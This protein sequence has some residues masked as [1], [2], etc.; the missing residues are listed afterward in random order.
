MMGF[1]DSVFKAAVTAAVVAAAVYYGGG[2]VGI[3]F[4]SSATAYIASAA[5]TAAAISTVSYLTAE[6]P[7]AFDLGEQLRGQLVT[8]REPA[9]NASIIYG[10]T[11]I[12]GTI[13]HM[14]ALGSKNE[15]M[16][17][18]IAMAGH[19]IAGVDN[20]YIN[21]DKFALTTSGNI[22]IDQL[23]GKHERYQLRLFGR[24]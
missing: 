2:A 21:D 14:E 5:L 20:V 1:F 16:Y 18:A 10:K 6:T 23:S 7:D 13:V 24:D 17:M 15:T 3:T 12:G 22:Y 11:R 4:A 8:K 9:G 19:E